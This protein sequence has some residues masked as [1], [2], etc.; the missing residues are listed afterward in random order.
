MNLVDEFEFTFNQRMLNLHLESFVLD[1]SFSIQAQTPPRNRKWWINYVN[2]FIV[3][4]WCNVSHAL[5]KYNRQYVLQQW[6][7]HIWK[8]CDYFRNIFDTSI[9]LIQGY[10]GPSSPLKWCQ[11]FYTILRTSK[12][13]ILFSWTVWHRQT[14]SV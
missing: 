10:P 2:Y 11:Q 6:I 3:I 4:L 5:I 9:L 8:C 14:S 1:T 7:F 12:L 13:L